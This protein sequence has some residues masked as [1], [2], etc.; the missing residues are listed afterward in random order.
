[1]H[2]V[3]RHGPW[4][5][6]NPGEAFI[7]Q[8]YCSNRQQVCSRS[9]TSDVPPGEFDAGEGDQ[10]VCVEGEGSS[11]NVL[12]D[13][14]STRGS[15]LSELP[16]RL[17]RVT[18]FHPLLASL[19]RYSSDPTLMFLVAKSGQ[20]V[21]VLE[22]LSSSDVQGLP[23]LRDHLDRILYAT[24][25]NGSPWGRELAVGGGSPAATHAADG[26]SSGRVQNGS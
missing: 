15:S 14:S 4:V 19:S 26:S 2:G 17:S 21:L 23:G 3:R 5:G 16:V 7:H 1:M 25:N 9:A 10:E 8:G 6:A 12:E 20:N 13:A 24:C 18:S 22:V 11:G